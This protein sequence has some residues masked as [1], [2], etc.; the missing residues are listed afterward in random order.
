M[1]GQ[2]SAV[3]AGPLDPDAH[4]RAQRSQPAQKPRIAVAVRRER[5]RAQQPPRGVDRGGDMDVFV[6]VDP[7]EDSGSV[8]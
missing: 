4:H 8:C 2:P 3:G 6:G 7:A 5:R 1:A